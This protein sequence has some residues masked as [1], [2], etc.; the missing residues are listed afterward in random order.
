MLTSEQSLQST[1]VVTATMPETQD[2]D[3]TLWS[4]AAFEEKCTYI[5][6]DQPLEQ[7]SENRGKTRAERSLP[8][9]LGL[10]RC[11]NSTEVRSDADS[12][13]GGEI[14]FVRSCY[15]ASFKTVAEKW[16]RIIKSIPCISLGNMSKRC[17]SMNCSCFM[18]CYCLL[19]ASLQLPSMLSSILWQ[20][21][22]DVLLSNFSL[23][24]VCVE[25]KAGTI[26]KTLS[27]LPEVPVISSYLRFSTPLSPAHNYT[28]KQSSGAGTH[29][30]EMIS[31]IKWVE[32]N[33]YLTGLTGDVE[34]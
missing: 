8:R 18:F 33:F 23:C 28:V 22:L 6:N 24:C 11:H 16:C 3:M 14:E 29:L 13:I 9:N 26:A 21:V 20:E 5:V 30:M 10:R 32:D 2:V 7:E 15:N 12:S 25:A 34:S 17:V 19:L 31:Q 27:T 1:R 4:E